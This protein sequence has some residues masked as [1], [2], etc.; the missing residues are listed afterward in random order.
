M[1]IFV[2]DGSEDAAFIYDVCSA[3]CIDWNSR[4]AN[5]SGY[6]IQIKRSAADAISHVG[7]QILKPEDGRPCAFPASPNA[8][9]RVAALLV[10]LSVHP[11]LVVLQRN[12]DDGVFSNLVYGDP[13]KPFAVE[14]I[15][16][17]LPIVF[18]ALDV[19]LEDGTWVALDKWKGF[20]TPGFR[21][22][23]ITKFLWQDNGEL[24]RFDG[25]RSSYNWP[26]MEAEVLNL[27]L[28]LEAVYGP[29]T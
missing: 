27:A 8:F 21:S 19:C 24:F 20:P 1:G 26:R 9:K 7:G 12:G 13:V 3:G 23:F 28:T 25:G 15:V 5:K 22:E 18:S 17:T 11:L 29:I 14:F 10:S 16:D 2:E 6:F 4:Y